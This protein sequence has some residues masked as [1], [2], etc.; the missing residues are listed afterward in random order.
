MHMPLSLRTRL[1]AE[2]ALAEKEEERER[3]WRFA[4]LQFGRGDEEE[5]EATTE[6][7]TPTQKPAT[8]MSRSMRVVV[9]GQGGD[10]P[11]TQKMSVIDYS[12][13][14]EWLKDPDDPVSLVRAVGI[15][16]VS[17]MIGRNRLS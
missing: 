5:E 4:E 9:R 15:F 16:L 12:K 17:F 2:K 13:W 14:E 10:E 8:S 6:E 3:W 7:V 11:S 1:Q